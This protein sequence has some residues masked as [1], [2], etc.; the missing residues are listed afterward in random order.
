M[1]NEYFEQV[2]VQEIDLTCMKETNGGG[3]IVSQAQLHAYNDPAIQ[4]FCKNLVW[5]LFKVFYFRR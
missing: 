4:E 2:G 5:G 1:N 3:L